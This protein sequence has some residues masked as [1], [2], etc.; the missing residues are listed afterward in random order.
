M[1]A[2][3][4]RFTVAELARSQAA[5]VSRQTLPGLPAWIYTLAAPFA[6]FIAGYVIKVTSKIASLDIWFQGASAAIVNAP[7]NSVID[8]DGTLA[9][10]ME[11]LESTVKAFDG[12]VF[13]A[14]G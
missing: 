9:F 3:A 2:V 1:N 14:C 7:A 11:E 5:E 8:V 10:V 13:G 12:F 6:G 4:H